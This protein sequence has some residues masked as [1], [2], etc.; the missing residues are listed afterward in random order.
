MSVVDEIG[1]VV[2]EVEKLRAKARELA[3]S[4]FER[5]LV[6]WDGSVICNERLA[7][8]QAIAID[9][10]AYDRF[11]RRG[12]LR[13]RIHVAPDVFE[14]LDMLEY[15]NVSDERRL[16]RREVDRWADDGGAA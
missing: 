4:P 6:D 10:M 3:A 9:E 7:P 8:G 1:R 12:P 14:A 2:R 15:S 16:R 5:M 13:V 11:F